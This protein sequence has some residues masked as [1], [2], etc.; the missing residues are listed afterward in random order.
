MRLSM[1]ETRPADNV[2]LNVDYPQEEEFAIG[3]VNPYNFY[4][5]W[6]FPD[7]HRELYEKYVRFEGVEDQVR[8]TWKHDYKNLVIKSLI[9]TKRSRAVFKNPVNTARVGILHET[10]PDARFIHIYRNPVVVYLSTKKFFK[11]LFPT[12]WFHEINEQQIID[13]I[14]ETYVWLHDDFFEQTKGLGPDRFQEIGFETFEQRPVEY[15]EEMYS[16]MNLSGFEEARP[17]FEAYIKAQKSYRKNTYRIKKE[18][19]DRVL[20][21]WGFAMKRWNYDVPEGLELI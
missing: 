3:N 8:E 13:M 5:F 15:L 4:Y 9:N 21:E 1:P 10:F 7:Q 17:A 12:L 14:M 6:Y 19:L 11:E 2:K 18:E 16:A 20:D